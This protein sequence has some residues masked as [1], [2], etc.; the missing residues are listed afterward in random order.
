MKKILK[1]TLISVISLFLIKPAFAILTSTMPEQFKE[2]QTIQSSEPDFGPFMRDLQQRIKHNWFPPKGEE[3]R[4]VVLLFTI[5]RDGSL[6][7]V[8]VLKS[9]GLAAADRAALAAVKMTAPFRPLPNGYSK[10]SVD[11]QF[12]FDY[13][14]YGAKKY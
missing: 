7:R 14:I 4:N 11:I 13:R 10:D 9:S 2:E 5:A 12:T 1:I 3:S 6:L 8:N